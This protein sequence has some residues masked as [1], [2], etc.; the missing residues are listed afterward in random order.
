M[1]IILTYEGGRKYTV[2]P[3]ARPVE[4]D[5]LYL[6]PEEINWIRKQGL[7]AQEFEYIYRVK[8]EDFRVKIITDPE[9]PATEV[10]IANKYCEAIKKELKGKK[11]ES[12]CT[13]EG[14]DWKDYPSGT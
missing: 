13:S 11:D 12:Q 14:Q 9:P 1:S 7:G 3:I 10:S 8:K 5:V 4:G 2:S 6:T